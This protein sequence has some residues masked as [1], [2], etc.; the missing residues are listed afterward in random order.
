MYKLQLKLNGKLTWGGVGGWITISTAN[1][2]VV[3]KV[4][5]NLDKWRALV[6]VWS[7]VPSKLAYGKNLFQNF[8]ERK[9][10]TTTTTKKHTHKKKKKAHDGKNMLQISAEMQEEMPFKWTQETVAVVPSNSK[11]YSCYSFGHVTS[12]RLQLSAMVFLI[13][14]ESLV[15]CSHCSVPSVLKGFACFRVSEIL[16]PNKILSSES[17]NS[18]KIVTKGMSHLLQELFDL[19]WLPLHHHC[20]SL[21]FVLSL[22]CVFCRVHT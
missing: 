3:H 14:A 11:V 1:D 8:W 18:K 6:T 2:W 20:I 15:L 4:A 21:C 7:T 22:F 13:G 16:F 5:Q 9:T 19:K 12:R 10:T 17:P